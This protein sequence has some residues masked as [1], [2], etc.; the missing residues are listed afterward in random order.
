MVP[1]VIVTFDEERFVTEPFEEVSVAIVPLVA[2]KFVPVAEVKES[3]VMVPF[4][5]FRVEI[6]PL[7]APKEV[8][9]RPVEVTLLPVAFVKVRVPRAEAPETASV[10]N[11]PFVANKFVEVTLVNT[12]VEGTLAPIVVPLIDPPEMVAFEETKVGA[13]SVVIVPLVARKLV[14]VAEVNESEL[15]VPFVANKFVEVTFANTPFQRRAPE[16][17]DRVA[18]AVGSRFEVTPPVTAKNEEVPLVSV[19]FWSEVVPVTVRFEM[20]APP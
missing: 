9:K 19:V 10:V 12:P 7:V 6:V 15:M 17:K 16:P 5:E 1:P 13:V 20:A 2:R 18:S 8:A 11:E 14:P 3:D 4:V